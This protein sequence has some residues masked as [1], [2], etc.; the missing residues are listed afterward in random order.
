MQELQS[1]FRS[2]PSKLS[3]AYF[4]SDFRQRRIDGRRTHL[5]ILPHSH[6]SENASLEKVK[7]QEFQ[8][9]LLIPNKL[10]GPRS[11]GVRV[12]TVKAADGNL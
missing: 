2:K 10:L 8:K 11:P 9:N 3:Q 4:E 12:L 7:V 5:R 6:Q 1:G